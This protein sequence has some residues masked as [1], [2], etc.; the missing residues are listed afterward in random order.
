MFL[1]YFNSDNVKHAENTPIHNKDMEILIWGF[2][3]QNNE[4]NTSIHA[5]TNLCQFFWA[6]EELQAS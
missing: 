5:T 2:S 4:V 6:L 1:V 3:K